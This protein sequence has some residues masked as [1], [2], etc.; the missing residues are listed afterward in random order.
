MQQWLLYQESQKNEFILKPIQ[1]TCSGAAVPP[2]DVPHRARHTAL[3][4]ITQLIQGSAPQRVLRV[5]AS[6]TA[7]PG[8]RVA[9]GRCFVRCFA[10]AMSATIGVGSKLLIDLERLANQ[11]G[12]ETQTWET[13]PRIAKKRTEKID[14]KG[15]RFCR[16]CFIASQLRRRLGR[17]AV[18][19]S[20]LYDCCFRNHTALRALRADLYDCCFRSHTALR[21]SCSRTA[22]C[23][24]D[25]MHSCRRPSTRSEGRGPQ[26]RSRSRSSAASYPARR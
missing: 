8:H 19:I 11:C 22:C 7:R 5:A 23:S 17:I 24:R 6:P 26:A 3:P 18:R 2:R 13:Y 12:L 21:A 14:E 25:Q 20:D 16:R 15:R 9:S 1:N 4:R 10:A